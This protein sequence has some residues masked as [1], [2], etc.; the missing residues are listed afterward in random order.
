MTML[1]SLYLELCDCLSN[2]RD[3]SI[4]NSSITRPLIFLFCSLTLEAVS[5]CTTEMIPSIFT[6]ICILHLVCNSPDSFKRSAFQVLD[7]Y[8]MKANTVYNSVE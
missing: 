3:I 1:I 5:R 8:S 7:Y 4:D 6:S 2:Y